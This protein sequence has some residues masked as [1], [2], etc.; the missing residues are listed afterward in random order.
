MD[1]HCICIYKPIV[2]A[3]ILLATD[4]WDT[5]SPKGAFC[6]HKSVRSHVAPPDCLF[7]DLW[8]E[9]TTE[10]VGDH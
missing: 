7:Y 3:I 6:G 4:N 8:E 9:G 10:K 5:G 1:K 2:K